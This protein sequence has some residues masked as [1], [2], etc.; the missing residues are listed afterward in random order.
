MITLS[1]PGITVKK[2]DLRLNPIL[3]SSYDTVLSAI[4]R[5]LVLFASCW[6]DVI[7]GA[8]PPGAMPFNFRKSFQIVAG[9]IL[10]HRAD[11][12]EMQYGSVTRIRYGCALTHTSDDAA[13]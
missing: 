10:T 12:D 1:A 11:G 8:G 6:G 9:K 2:D 7:T 4:T 13:V 5:Y 3:M